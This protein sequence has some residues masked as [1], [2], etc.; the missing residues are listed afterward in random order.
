MSF[1]KNFFLRD[2]LS[3][4]RD[5]LGAKLTTVNKQGSTSGIIVEVEA[6]GAKDEASHS[7]RGITK[8]NSIMFSPGG[9]CYVYL[10]YGM[11]YCVNVVTEAEGI[12]SAVLI[13][14]LSPLE[15]IDLMKK[16]RGTDQILNLCSGPAKL[17]EALDIDKSCNGENLLQSKKIFLTPGDKVKESDVSY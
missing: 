8:R 5:L 6:Y 3:V 1:N 7:F 11:H 2:P 15:G 16:R 9:I 14:A 13:R 12:G 10:I 17:C 4:A